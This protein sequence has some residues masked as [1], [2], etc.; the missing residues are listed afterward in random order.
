MAERYSDLENDQQITVEKHLEAAL[1][2]CGLDY[3]YIDPLTDALDQAVDIH[4][5]EN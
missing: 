4:N 2:A 3:H 5:E 1:A